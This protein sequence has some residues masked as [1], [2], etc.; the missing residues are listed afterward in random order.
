MEE[1]EKKAKPEYMIDALTSGLV[2]YTRVISLIVIDFFNNQFFEEI[3][4]L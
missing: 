1:Y 3:L 4:N 2:S